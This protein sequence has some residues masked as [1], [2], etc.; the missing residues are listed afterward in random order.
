MFGK[1]PSQLLHQAYCPLTMAAL[2]VDGRLY[3][4]FW[5]LQA[6]LSRKLRRIVAV[7]AQ[8]ELLATCIRKLCMGMGGVKKHNDMTTVYVIICDTA[9]ETGLPSPID[10]HLMSDH[11]LPISTL[12]QALLITTVLGDITP[13]TCSTEGLVQRGGQREIFLL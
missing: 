12:H 1:T 9:S 8:W 11:A 4:L 3:L 2:R 10:W 7:A 6:G 5:E 13:G